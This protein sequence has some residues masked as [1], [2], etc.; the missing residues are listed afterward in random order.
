MGKVFFGLLI[1]AIVWLLFFAK[2]KLNRPSDRGTNDAKPSTIS[3]RM[4]SC[5]R[6]GVNIPESESTKD[7]SGNFCCKNNADCIGAPR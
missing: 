7:T 6:C 5:A 2:R 1:A 4:V 3:E